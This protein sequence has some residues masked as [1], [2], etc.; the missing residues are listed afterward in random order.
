MASPLNALQ[1]KASNSCKIKVL[2][3]LFINVKGADKVFRKNLESLTP[4]TLFSKKIGE[5]PEMRT[6]NFIEE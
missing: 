2:R 1:M 3:I 6:E 5:E 4:R